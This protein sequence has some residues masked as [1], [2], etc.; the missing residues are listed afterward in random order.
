MFFEILTLLPEAMEGYLAASILGRAQAAGLVE[1]RVTNI[2]EFATGKH[3]TADDRPYGGGNGMVMK[4][5]PLAKAIRAALP[6]RVVLTSPRGRPFDQ[7][8]ARE[9]AGVDKLILVCGRYEGVDQRLIDLLVD[10]EISVGDYV[11]TGGELPALIVLDATARL[12][13]GVLGG[14]GSA[15]EDSFSEGLL[16]YPHYTRPRVF[17][18]RLTPQVLLSGDHESIRRWRRRESLWLTLQ[19]RP[20]LLAQAALTEEDERLLA[21]LKAEWGV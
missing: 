8:K 16:E 10:E 2:R 9:L 13:P 3:R 17:E 4:P 18:D 21:E 12:I 7:A 6:G 20:E 1:I 19:R 15:G 14:E 5:E 11:L